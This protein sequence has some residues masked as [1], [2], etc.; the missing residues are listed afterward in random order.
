MLRIKEKD[1]YSFSGSKFGGIVLITRVDNEGVSG[2]TLMCNKDSGEFVESEFC[3][4]L[5]WNERY[6]FFRFFTGTTPYNGEYI[7]ISP[8]DCITNIGVTF[9]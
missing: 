1:V 3:T 8:S 6:E 4:S 9:N 5:Y 7:N 2:R